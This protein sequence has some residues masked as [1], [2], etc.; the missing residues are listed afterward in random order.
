MTVLEEKQ[1]FYCELT[2]YIKF[3][4]S[5]SPWC[6]LGSGL[7]CSEYL[8]SSAFSKIVIKQKHRGLQQACTCSFSAKFSSG[9]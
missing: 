3:K 7:C 6:V 2:L 9:T 4:M 5:A 1:I 8:R